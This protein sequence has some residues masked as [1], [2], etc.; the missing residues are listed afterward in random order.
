MGSVRACNSSCA[1]P[2]LHSGFYHSVALRSRL[3]RVWLDTA[4]LC[5]CVSVCTHRSL[6]E[7]R[8]LQDIDFKVF[9]P[10]VQRVSREERGAVMDV[11]HLRGGRDVVFSL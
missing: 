7:R 9:G 10:K 5:L 8:S 4:A 3:R 11:S 1:K 2:P 6:S